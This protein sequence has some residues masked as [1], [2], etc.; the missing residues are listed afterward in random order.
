M[1]PVCDRCGKTLRGGRRFPFT[2]LGLTHD[3]SARK[4]GVSGRTWQGYMC[5]GVGREAAERI[6]NRLGV[7]PYELWPDM[8]DHDAG[9]KPCEECGKPFIPTRSTQRMCSPRCR[10]RRWQRNRYQNDPDW[11]A[12]D[13]AKSRAYYENYGDYCRQ[14]QRAYTQR[15]EDTA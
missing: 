11:R 5:H 4:L 14:R 3:Q 12:R 1:S 7:H 2:T 8:I 13:V 6:A 9:A 15:L 10:S